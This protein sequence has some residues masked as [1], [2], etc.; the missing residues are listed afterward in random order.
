MNPFY[1]VVYNDGTE[2]TLY[3]AELANSYIEQMNYV[4]RYGEQPYRHVFNIYK[5]VEHVDGKNV[6][7][8]K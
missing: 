6:V 8:F 1:T 4:N 7:I 5:I 3:T 2:R